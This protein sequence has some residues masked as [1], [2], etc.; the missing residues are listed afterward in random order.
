[1]ILAARLWKKVSPRPP[2]QLSANA[3]P[4]KNFALEFAPSDD[5]PRNAPPPTKFAAYSKIHNKTLRRR[6]TSR[7]FEP[8]AT[9]PIPKVPKEHFQRNLPS[10][11]KRPAKPEK[12][13]WGGRCLGKGVWG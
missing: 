9:S 13:I 3:S 10:S 7:L 11:R 6:R 4:R 12:R 2:A 1:M 5:S 8:I